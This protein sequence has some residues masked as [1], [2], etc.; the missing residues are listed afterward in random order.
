MQAK[1]KNDNCYMD[2]GCMSVDKIF[3]EMKLANKVNLLES[4]IRFWAQKMNLTI[5]IGNVI[6]IDSVRSVGWF[7]PYKFT[8]QPSERTFFLSSLPQNEK[9]KKWKLRTLKAIE[10]PFGP[11]IFSKS[12]GT[13]NEDEEWVWKKVKRKSN[14]AF[15]EC[16]WA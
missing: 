12:N 8:F 6:F 13:K 16:F 11:L 1:H 5:W 4:S 15:N 3:I 9:K 10:P 7:V 14:C 2:V